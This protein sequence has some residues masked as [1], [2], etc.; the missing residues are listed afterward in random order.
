MHTKLHTKLYEAK[1]SLDPSPSISVATY[2]ESQLRK[3]RCPRNRRKPHQ[4]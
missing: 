1:G 3:C 4:R 2:L